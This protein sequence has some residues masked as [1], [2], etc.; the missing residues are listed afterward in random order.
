VRYRTLLIGLAL[1]LLAVQLGQADEGVSVSEAKKDG[2]GFLVHEARSP[3]Q[4]GTTP[5]RV[6]PP[7]NPEPGK[8][9]PAAYV[10]P[11]EADT[12]HR[13]GDGLAEVKKLDLHYKL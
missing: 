6:P 2:D 7:D 11:V 1:S 12:K 10:L 9:Y 13:Y 3:Y 8:K 4:S 5:I